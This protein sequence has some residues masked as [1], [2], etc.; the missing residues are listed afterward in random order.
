MSSSSIR[1]APRII[2]RSE[3]TVPRVASPSH[4]ERARSPREN[5]RVERVSPPRARAV[6]RRIRA[7]DGRRVRNYVDGESPNRDGDHFLSIGQTDTLSVHTRTFWWFERYQNCVCSHSRATWTSTRTT[8][9]TTRTTTQ[10]TTRSLARL[11][12][13]SGAFFL[14]AARL[15]TMSL[16]RARA[17]SPDR[18]EAKSEYS[19]NASN[20]MNSRATPGVDGFGVINYELYASIPLWARVFLA[21]TN[22]AYWLLFGAV[23]KRSGAGALLIRGL[24][25]CASDVCRSHAF[26]V[27]LVFSIAFCSTV[28]HFLQLGMD[29][30]VKKAARATCDCFKF[31]G[32]SREKLR[33]P[34][35]PPKGG[36]SRMRSDSARELCTVSAYT[37]VSK[38]LHLQIPSATPGK[39]AMWE[40]PVAWVKFLCALDVGCAVMYGAFCGVC[41]GV[42][43]TLRA[44]PVPLILLFSAMWCQRN[45][46]YWGYVVLH[47]VWHVQSAALTLDFLLDQ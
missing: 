42:E 22:A 19:K 6:A 36:F 40:Y 26:H 28:Y 7:V 27:A 21:G 45:R 20:K 23:V 25:R 15:E 37:N 10:R 41:F 4:D 31:R 24:P 8:T 5:K 13:V 32:F 16:A 35:T 34:E 46:Y 17:E 18:W 39:M 30:E 2:R 44:G 29:H 14:R 12:H 43:R 3:I 11:A 38:K 47:S 1:S 9:R 33:E